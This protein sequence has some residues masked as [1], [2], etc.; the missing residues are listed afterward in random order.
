MRPFRVAARGAAIDHVCDR[1]RD[2]LLHRF[3]EFTE[4][5]WGEEE[6]TGQRGGGGAQRTVAEPGDVRAVA[7]GGG[8][9]TVVSGGG[10]ATATVPSIELGFR[11]VWGDSL[12]STIEGY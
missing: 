10:L 2:P 6:G 11:A 4:S 9:A 3:V 1:L 12:P 8:G 5:D 7:H